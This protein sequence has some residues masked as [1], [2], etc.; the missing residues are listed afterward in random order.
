MKK[1]GILISLYFVLQSVTAQIGVNLKKYGFLEIPTLT[2]NEDTL[3]KKQGAVTLYY[4][5]IL[6]YRKGDEGVELWDCFHVIYKVYDNEKIDSYKKLY[7]PASEVE[8]IID[9]QARC[10]KKNGEKVFL[11]KKDITEIEEDGDTDKYLI[12]TTAEPEDIMEF[13]YI[14]RKNNVNDNGSYYFPGHYPIKK[15]EFT[16]ILPDYLKAEFTTYNL[17]S[18][19]TDSLVPATDI[20]YSYITAENLPDISNEEATFYEVY[21][22]RIE[23]VIAY[24]YSRG[25]SRLNTIS[26]YA[27]DL[28]TAIAVLSKEENA[29]MKK[30]LSKIPVNKKMNTLEKIRIIESYIKKEIIFINYSNST[31]SDISFAIKS[32]MTNTL[33]LAKMYYYIFK[34]FGIE[35]N[36]VFTTDK[37]EKR[38]DKKFE[39]PNYVQELMFYFPE[40]DQYLAPAYRNLRIGLTPSALTGQDALFLETVSVGKV[41]SFVPS[42]KTIPV[43]AKEIS[44]DSI[45]VQVQIDAN[46]KYMKGNIYRVMTGY[47]SAGIQNNLATME[48]ED[49]QSVLDNYLALESE[50]ISLNNVEFFNASAADIFINPLIMKADIIDY[51]LTKFEDNKITT[52]IGA[53]IGKQSEFKQ[54]TKRL[55]PVE[56]SHK[57]KY[58]R[59]I[60]CAIPEG[61]ECANF[62]TL[63]TAVYDSDNASTAKAAFIITVKKEGNNIVIISEEYYDTLFYPVDEY[64]RYQRVVNAAAAFNKAVLVFEK[65]K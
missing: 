39:G 14:V 56:R 15:A 47:Y 44:T 41:T 31:F 26:S 54:E 57:S 30:F 1:L 17:P 52:N 21:E 50:S 20:R 35:N 25:N 36:V 60:V 11:T 24:N 58:Y 45:N 13:Y 8:N 40:I 2:Q 19:V 4:G 64:Q 42:F 59:K 12:L 46:K 43:L 61:Y 51:Y 9:C 62:N 65:Q 5:R 48:D 34:H 37:T 22:P 29:L 23:F 3:F 27:S 16:M 63:E 18:K 6:D 7:I 55:L 38:F 33:G 32:K 28:Y 10:I 49:K 53:L